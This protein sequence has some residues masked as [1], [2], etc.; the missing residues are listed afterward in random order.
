MNK[1]ELDLDMKSLR[2]LCKAAG[3]NPDGLDRD[4]MIGKLSDKPKAKKGV[5]EGL[6]SS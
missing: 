2:L 3:I 5:E 1:A 6:D 4:E